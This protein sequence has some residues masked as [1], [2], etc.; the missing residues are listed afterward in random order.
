LFNSILL[1][2]IPKNLLDIFFE[3]IIIS[4]HNLSRIPSCSNNL[5]LDCFIVYKI[6]NISFDLIENYILEITNNIYYFGRLVT[7]QVLVKKDIDIYRY[8]EIIEF[9]SIS[10]ENI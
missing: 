8:K 9:S 6:I 2:D 1:F 5:P 7:K 4:K 10:I 3:Y